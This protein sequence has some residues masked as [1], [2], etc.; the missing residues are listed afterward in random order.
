MRMLLHLETFALYLPFLYQPRNIHL[1]C[2]PFKR[3]ISHSYNYQPL[4]KN[5]AL[6]QTYLK[7]STATILNLG[8]NIFEYVN[9]NCL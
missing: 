2:F 4:Q 8:L 6:Y 5:S 3:Q 7:S 1:Q 9:K